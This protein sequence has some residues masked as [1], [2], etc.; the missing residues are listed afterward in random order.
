MDSDHIGTGFTN[1]TPADVIPQRLFGDE[2]QVRGQLVVGGQ[3]IG[4]VVAGGVA[5]GFVC[6]AEQEGHSAE[7]REAAAQRTQVLA[8][9]SV[10]PIDE[11]Q[12]VSA[13]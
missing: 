3:P 11:Q 1:R 12:R 5:T 10:V 4:V 2:R 6:A 13:V 7:P 8:V 9:S